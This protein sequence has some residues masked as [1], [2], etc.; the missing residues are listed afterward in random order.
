MYSKTRFG[1]ILKGLPRGEFNRLV[2]KHQTNKFSKGFKSWDQLVSMVYSQLSNCKSLREL[3]ESF[4]SQALHHYHLGTRAIKRSTLAEANTKRTSEL[5]ADVCNLLIQNAHRKSK[6]ELKEMLYL[7]DSSPIV[8]K[9]LGFDTWTSS[10]RNNRF[11]GLKLHLMIEGTGSIP[12]YMNMTG[13]QVS[14]IKEGREI[15]LESNATYV[16]DKGYYDYNWWFKIDEIGSR[17][18]TRIKKNANVSV[19]ELHEIPEG[20]D[21]ILEV[22]LNQI[23]ESS[24]PK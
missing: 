17:F 12:S 18:V 4:N 23:Q 3:E 16:F 9:G 11:Q 8:L 21:L 14:D 1:Q 13:A 10:L 6:R 15:P 22:C 19:E 2:E 5:F 7:L 20:E 24:C